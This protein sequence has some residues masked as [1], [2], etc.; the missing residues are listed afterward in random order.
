MK[1]LL[2]TTTI[3]KIRS[4]DDMNDFVGSLGLTSD[5]VIVKPNWVD[6]CLGTHTEAKVLDLFFGS[7]K[8]KRKYL[9]ESYTFWRNEKSTMEG[10]D[11]FSSSEAQFDTGKQH[12]DFFKTGDK[13]FLKNTGVDQV[14]NKYDIAYINVTDELWSGRESIVP[15]V[16]QKLYD[17]KGSD[18]VSFA[19]LKGDGDYGA[20]LSI[21]NLFGLYPDPHWGKY[22][23]G[24]N[25]S[26]IKQSILNINQKYRS[27]FNFFSVVEGVYFA[28]HVNWT[29][30]I[31]RV[32]RDLGVIVGGKDALQVDD[33]V[34]KLMSANLD[35]PL[36]TMLVNYKNIFGGDFQSQKIPSEYKIDFSKK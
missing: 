32:Y 21:K 23:H 31:H 17:L 36:E 34:L 35:G 6:G 12:W 30:N 2:D 4:Q 8:N 16:P 9:V 28:S 1:T 15:L 33:T 14:I 5:T 13:W 20:T 22:Y 10:K 27:L 24:D 29:E 3:A 25:D 7:L 19:K 18:F 26:K 11:S